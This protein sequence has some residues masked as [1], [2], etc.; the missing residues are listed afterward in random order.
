MHCTRSKQ[1]SVVQKCTYF[2]ICNFRIAHLLKEKSYPK[3][4]QINKETKADIM[5]QSGFGDTLTTPERKT[6]ASF[7]PFSPKTRTLELNTSVSFTPYSQESFSIC[8]KLDD[9]DTMTLNSEDECFST[10][11]QESAFEV[12][13]FH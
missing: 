2:L 5:E 13:T 1:S 10:L 8:S 3:K 11:K 6:Y 4:D 9:D 12:N 7:I